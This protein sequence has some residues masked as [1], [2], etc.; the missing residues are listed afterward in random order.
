MRKKIFVVLLA[1]G[2]AKCIAQEKATSPFVFSGYVETYYCYDFNNPSDHNRPVFFYNYK[3][4]NEVNLNLGLIKVSYAK[5]N[6]RGNFGIMSGTYS[7]FNMTG[8]LD[9][10]KNVYEA[11][12]GVK[13]SQKSNLWLDAG[14]LPSHIGFE[15][16]IGKDCMTLSRSL[17]A[18]NTPYFEAGVRLGYASPSEKWYLAVMYLN[19]WQRM[20]T[21]EGN[22]TPCFGTQVTYKTTSETTLNWSTYIGNDEPDISRRW[23]Y[24]NDFYGQFKISEKTRVIAGFDI[25]I[26]QKSRASNNYDIWYNPTLIFQYKP[27]PKIQLAAR[28]E[29]YKDKNGVIVA[30]ETPNGFQTFS[31]SANFDYRI[32]DN[33][34]FRIEARS[35]NSKDNIFTKDNNPAKTNT[36]ITTSLAISF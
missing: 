15:S 20:Q 14:V 5:D 33:A 23:R 11:N 7:Q 6:I 9:L 4:H 34:L 21:V 25:G 3:R 35:L 13:I 26:Q 29:Y 31:Y 12:V 27:T 17:S 10:V 19:G 32:A 2:L 22:Q 8:E 30:T 1:I 16:A 28:S 18:E 36:F 24:F